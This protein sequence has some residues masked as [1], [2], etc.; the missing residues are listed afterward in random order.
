MYPQ[1]KKHDQRTSEERQTEHFSDI[2]L[3]TLSRVLSHSHP[4]KKPSQSQQKYVRAMAKWPL[5]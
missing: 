4:V 5:L 3:L 2:I 1:G